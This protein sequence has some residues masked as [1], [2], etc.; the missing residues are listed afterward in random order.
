MP[1][2]EG[3]RLWNRTLRILMVCV[4]IG[5][6]VGEASAGPSPKTPSSLQKPG[7]VIRFVH[8]HERVVSCRRTSSGTACLEQRVATKAATEIVLKPVAGQLVSVPEATRTAAHLRVTGAGAAKGE[9]R[10]DPGDWELLWEDQSSVMHVSEQRDFTV[11][12]DSIS[13]ACILVDQTCKRRDGT[14]R[15]VVSIPAEFA[16]RQ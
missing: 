6:A 9:L 13:G 5:A 12:L 3:N 11:G 1:R 16:V 15:H 8:T 2:T 14:V 7:A 10:L 4:G